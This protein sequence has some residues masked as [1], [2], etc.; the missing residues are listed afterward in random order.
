MF[1]RSIVSKQD[2]SRRQNLHFDS[3]PIHLLKTLLR[4]P[5]RGINMAEETITNH[6][7]RFA[8]LSVFDPGPV[9]RPVASRQVRPGAG[10]EVIM[11]VDDGH[12]YSTVCRDESR[13]NACT[14]GGSR[15]CR[16]VQTV[17]EDRARCYS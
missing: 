9:G 10:K 14:C 4:I 11:N 16:T 2:R 8:R 7:V 6:D 3:V 17:E 5:A 13:R 12:F 1:N 15:C